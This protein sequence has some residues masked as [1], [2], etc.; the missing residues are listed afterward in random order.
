MPVV[1]RLLAGRGI[2]AGVAGL[3]L[4]A[5]ASAQ[6]PDDP[7][8]ASNRL[9]DPWV[10]PGVR[11]TAADA[12]WLV[13]AAEPQPLPPGPPGKALL[14]R[15]TSQMP[16]NGPQAAAP[17]PVTWSAPVRRPVASVL[18]TSTRPMIPCE[19]AVIA[20]VAAPL[21]EAPLP[22]PRALTPE[23]GEQQTATPAPPAPPPLPPPPAAAPTPSVPEEDPP[24]RP[25]TSIRFLDD[26]PPPAVDETTLMAIIRRGGTATGNAAD[27]RA[28]VE[29]ICRGKV[30][31]CQTE[32]AG[33]RQVRVMLTVHTAADWQRL[34]ERMQNL[35]ELGEYGLLFQVRV[36]K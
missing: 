26:P 19:P 31:A 14:S 35:A 30:A 28:A 4:A 12:P 33:E 21:M 34:Y 25:V 1:L 11:L 2:W 10:A 32:I 6:P 29:R 8:A 7:I 22:P 3:A 15:I 9:I 13:P 17:A 18:P 5:P 27:I 20:P 23:D 36:E 16:A 24:P